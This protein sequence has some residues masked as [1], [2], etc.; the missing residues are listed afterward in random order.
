MSGMWI[1]WTL[2]LVGVES[3]EETGP[4]GLRVIPSK[5]REKKKVYQSVI[6]IYYSFI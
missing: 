4:W 3:G 6:S 1:C 5:A 2:V